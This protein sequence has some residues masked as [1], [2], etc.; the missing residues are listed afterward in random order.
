[1]CLGVSPAH[2]SLYH[3]YAQCPQRP[4]RGTGAPR[5]GVIESFEPP[6][7]CWES[8]QDPLEEQ[9]SL[10][11]RTT[12]MAEDLTH[13]NCIRLTSPV[14]TFLSGTLSRAREFFQPLHVQSGTVNVHV[15]GQESSTNQGQEFVSRTWTFY[16]S[17]A[18]NMQFF[19]ES[20]TGL[21]T[22]P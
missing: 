18:Y 2:V 15:S 6:S 4:E 9:P 12:V 11:R 19:M 10:Q 8:Y 17:E 1:M 7:G 13:A 16:I 14:A 21:S 3:K 20:T 22:V 5:T